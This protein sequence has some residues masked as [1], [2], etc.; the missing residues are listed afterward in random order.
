MNEFLLPVKVYLE[1]TDAGGIVYHVNYLK[2]LERS[3][4]EFFGQLGYDKPALL[5]AEP[6]EGRA[7]ER[8]LVVHS[9][10]I[11]Y[12][13]TAQLGDDLQA[14]TRIEQLKRTYVVF[15]QWVARAEEVV[16]RAQ[17]KVACINKHSHKPQALP[18]ALRE[19]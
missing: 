4:T 1:D 17:V 18:D 9:L 19:A 2:Y 15:E 12:L 13:R 6:G 14:G 5:E 11:D 8:I 16:C 3:R 10:A 7:A